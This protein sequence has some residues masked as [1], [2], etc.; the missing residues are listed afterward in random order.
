MRY[1][2]TLG[3]ILGTFKFLFSHWSIHVAALGNDI[4]LTFFQLFIP[5][6]AG[7]LIT[8]IIFYFSSEALMKRAAIK[9]NI[10][11]HN[12][13]AAGLPYV[14]KKKFTYLNKKIVKIKNGIGIYG[15]TFLAPLFLSIPI[16]SV[17]CAKFYR[18]KKKTFP[19]M[20][21]TVIGYSFLMS[22][23]IAIIF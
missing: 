5:T 13:L 19:L 6:T 9:R 21:F 15:I 11:Y 17:I 1:I 10:A 14:E 7:A 20:L 3:F 18:H 4:E 23:I 2:Y 12:A 22:F 8:M 16:G